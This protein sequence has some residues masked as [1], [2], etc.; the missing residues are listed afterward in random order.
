MEFGEKPETRAIDAIGELLNM[1]KLFTGSTNEPHNNV[2]MYDLFKKTAPQY[3]D[4]ILGIYDS[5]R[6]DETE[7]IP[8]VEKIK[9]SA[10]TYIEKNTTGGEGWPELLALDGDNTL[11]VNV[12]S[13]ESGFVDEHYINVILHLMSTYDKIV[14][15]LETHY[16]PNPTEAINNVKTSLAQL[17]LKNENIVI[18][19][20]QADVH[21]SVMR[22]CKHLLLHKGWYSAVGGLLFSGDKLYITGSFYLGFPNDIE[23]FSHLVNYTTI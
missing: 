5:Y 12:R 22:K 14:I 2:Y 11:F 10:D 17:Y 4:S 3:K 19:A 23:Y 16:L 20:N 1:S 15:L 9:L 8:N 13:N 18:D 6:T 21:L 7:P